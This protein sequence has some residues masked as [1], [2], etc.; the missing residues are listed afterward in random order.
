MFERLRRVGLSASVSLASLGLITSIAIAQIQDDDPIAFVGHGAIF[1]QAG[2][3]ISPT[4]QSMSTALAWYKA[5]LAARLTDAQRQDFNKLDQDL[6][7]GLTLDEQARLVVDASLVDWL[8]DTVPPEADDRIRQKNNAL[9]RI[10]RTKLWNQV[11][12]APSQPYAVDRALADRLAS[13]PLLTAKNKIIPF[14]LTAKGGEAYRAEC[15]AD[16]VPIPPDFGPGSGWTSQGKIDKAD[17]FIERSIDAEV[18][19]WTSASPS[20]ICV[21]LPRYDANNMVQLDGVICLGRDTSKTC[22]WD[23]EKNGQTFEFPLGTSRPFSDFGG[24]T[25]LQA[26]VGGVCSD[27]H[28][29]ENPYI[30]HGKILSSLSD[31]FGAEWYHPLVRTGDT[32]EWPQN[33]GPMDSPKACTACHGSAAQG[34]FA[35]R[36]PRL[37]SSLTGYCGAVMR[38]SIGA[39]A[40]PM[41]G[42][43]NTAPTM[44]QGKAAGTLACTPGLTSADPRYRP[45]SAATTVDCTPNFAAD[46]PRIKEPDFPNAY[47]VSCTADIGDLL[48]LCKLAS[49]K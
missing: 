36:L 41:P 26:S 35:G 20:G 34:E 16:G 4:L 19:S 38:S 10:L 1:S 25:E 14:D 32:V 11:T 5:R 37:S 21:A 40:P 2:N 45:C 48:N 28:A 3:E 27:C 8:L 44:P 46:D 15:L 13:N 47:K 29:G 22:F 12:E 9:K 24:G 33:P 18:L 43:V 30:I 23:N 6:R 31:T 42:R 17:L 49:V 39:L 7:T